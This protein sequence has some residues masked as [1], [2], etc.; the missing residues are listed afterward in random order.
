MFRLPA[1][2]LTLF[3]LL[4]VSFL[5]APATGQDADKV[6][7]MRQQI[8][9]ITKNLDDLGSVLGKSRTLDTIIRQ[10]PRGEPLAISLDVRA[11]EERTIVAFCTPDCDPMETRVTG[12]GGGEA[13]ADK[14]HPSVCSFTAEADGKHWA[15]V[16]PT[17]CKAARCDVGVIIRAKVK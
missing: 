12:P 10:I 8:A 5:A 13:C 7:Q 2:A 14:D 4:V 9:R 1:A 3:P 17:G 15:A 11:G 16:L 6:A